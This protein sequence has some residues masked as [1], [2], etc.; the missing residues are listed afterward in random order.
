M[1]RK[2]S[3]KLP[4][5]MQRNSVAIK[6]KRANEKDVSRQGSAGSIHCERSESRI[7]ATSIACGERLRGGSEALPLLPG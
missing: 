6:T 7:S 4:T 2:N 1:R 5:V 3:G